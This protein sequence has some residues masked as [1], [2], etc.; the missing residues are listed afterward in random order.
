MRDAS[1]AAWD[2]LV[3]LTIARGA[4]FLLL[5][6]DIYDGPQRGV[7]AQL[8]FLRGLVHP[9][10]GFLVPQPVLIAPLL[11]FGEVLFRDGAGVEV[12]FE[13]FLYQRIRVEP[14]DERFGLFPVGEA[15]VEFVAEKPREAG[16]F[17]GSGHRTGEI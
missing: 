11:P 4:A 3:E 17:A 7:R 1:L 13:H 5:A 8:R 15:L 16:D 2:N 6:G 12:K 10:E 14:G 9:C